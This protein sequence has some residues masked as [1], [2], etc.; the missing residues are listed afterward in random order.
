MQL[1]N[2]MS[3][4]GYD[5]LLERFHREGWTDGLPIVPP[6]PA[7]VAAML[8]AANLK[9]DA[10]ISFYDERSRPILAEKLAINAVM[11]GCLPDYFPVVVALVEALMTPEL[12]PHLANSSTASFT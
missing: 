1:E 10:E 3:L 8:A 6:T 11:A 12:R 2:D 9:R 4:D 5:G 7:R